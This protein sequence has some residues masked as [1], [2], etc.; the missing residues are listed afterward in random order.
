[1]TG[2]TAR[3]GPP[4]M[5]VHCPSRLIS[6]GRALKD[7][8]VVE[9]QAVGRLPARLHDQR[10]GARK[11]DRIV[12]AITVIVVRIEVRVQ[13]GEAEKPQAKPWLGAC[14]RRIHFKPPATHSS[15]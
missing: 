3:G 9:Q 13:V 8:A 7:V 1:M 14:E 15:S 6:Q 10:R 2:W 5:H 11:T 4:V 12:R